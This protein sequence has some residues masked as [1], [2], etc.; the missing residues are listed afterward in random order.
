MNGNIAL[1]TQTL[2]NNHTYNVIKT[3]KVLDICTYNV[4]T[5]HN[6]EHLVCF[7]NKVKDIKWDIIGLCERKLSNV[8][9]EA[10]KN[11]H[12]LY[13]SGVKENERRRNGVGLLVKNNFN[14]YVSEFKPISDRIAIMKIR[15]KY[16][17]GC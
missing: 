3:S 9:V 15:G 14:N 17:R 11:N 6:D 7:L 4:R 16:N 1:P 10:A 12:Y 2:F 13:N 8:F 5:L